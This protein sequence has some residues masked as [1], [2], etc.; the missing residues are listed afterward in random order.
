VSS[1][2]QA[3]LFD[4]DD[5]LL[6]NDMA[7]FGPAYLELFS[8]RLAPLSSQADMEAALRVSLDA[9]LRHDDPRVTNHERFRRELAACT[10]LPVDHLQSYIDR[11]IAEDFPRLQPLVRRRAEAAEIVRQARA[12]GLDVVLATNPMFPAQ[13][14]YRRMAWAGLD[15]KDFVRVTTPEN[16][17]A[18]KP[19]PSY[20]H[21]ILDTI[22]VAPKD[23][24]MV[25]ND[26]RMDIAPAIALGMATYWIAEPGRK[27]PSEVAPRVASGTW[28]EFL[29][30]WNALTD[31]HPR[32]SAESAETLSGD[33]VD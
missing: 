33:E 28:Q 24:L 26:W 6:E 5:T 18:C 16:S 31:A 20:F 30:W 19:S 23:A 4:L 14:I 10:D 21:E 17:H 29:A 25:G 9:V 22:D 15:A 27:R 8:R 7:T 12:R 13:A 32:K 1:S 11:F 2:L 3:V